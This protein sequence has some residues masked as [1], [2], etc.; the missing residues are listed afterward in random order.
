MLTT[1]RELLYAISSA[2][3]AI[4][5]RVLPA[6]STL[7]DAL[8][9]ID[10]GEFEVLIAACYTPDRGQPAY[11][12]L[13]LLKIELLSF[14]YCLSDR[15]VIERVQTDLLCRYFLQIGICAP[16]PDP[17]T[18]SRFRS[19][20]GEENFRK[21]FDALVGQA[22][23]RGLVK[24]RLRLTDSTHVIAAIAVPRALELV[25]QLRDKMIQ[26]IEGLSATDAEGFR[27]KMSSIRGQEEES[28]D[29]A[30]RLQSRVA[31]VASM[32]DW[33]DEYLK[34][35]STNQDPK[36][37]AVR[38]LASKILGEQPDPKKNDRTLSLVDPDARRGFHGDYYDGYSMS[39]LVDADSGICTCIDVL[40]ANAD[41]V[42]NAVDM[43][44][45]EEATHGNDIETLS[46]DGIGFH[47]PTLRELEDPQGLNIDVIT[48]PRD[49]SA[50][51][52]FDFSK[53]ENVNDGER[54]RCPAGH[55]SQKAESVGDGK[56]HIQTYQFAPSHCRDCPL[57]ALCH[58]TMTDTS[59]KGRK[60]R[61]NQY[62]PEFE[63]ARQKSKT[64]HYAR[65][66][67]EHPMVERKLNQMANHLRGRRSRYW[68]VA[69]NKI[70]ALMTGF[71]MNLK[72]ILPQLKMTS[73]LQ[74]A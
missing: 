10:W 7:L 46:I 47:G 68:G 25:A 42:R 9:E 55:L 14:L 28:T 22:R 19:R 31:I 4:Y 30:V 17:S 27:V 53:F 26:T 3:E 11:P 65:V 38:D 45:S 64:E 33:L 40:P 34:N 21:I 69:K 15:Q 70:Q 74:A 39:I 60:V 52:G 62:A 16:L 6:K 41:E 12:P 50:T 13:R 20:L 61:I 24:D 43:V 37:I 49:F 32:L 18:L 66:R 58:P 57:R 23:K 72:A 56:D 2:D 1:H 29:P 5:S 63:R 59:R 36:V 73:Q 71:V 35:N 44:K 8:D 48:P 54:L 51:P 67:S